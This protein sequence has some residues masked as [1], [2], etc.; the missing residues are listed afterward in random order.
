MSE[1]DLLDKFQDYGLIKNI[2]LNLDRRT[3]YV[4]GYCLVEF[5]EYSQARGMVEGVREM[6][7]RHTASNKY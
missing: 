5:C 2:H 7:T 6:V 3:G 1:E 4:K